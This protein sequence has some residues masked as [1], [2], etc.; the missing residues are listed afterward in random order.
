TS[1]AWRLPRV[2]HSFL[3]LPTSTSTQRTVSS[4]CQAAGDVSG[5]Q[6]GSHFG[7]PEGTTPPLLGSGGLDTS[8][9]ELVS[10]ETMFTDRGK[11]HSRP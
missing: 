2:T 8:R 3:R 11:A 9:A 5:G 10:K 7:G 4:A 6:G 1:A